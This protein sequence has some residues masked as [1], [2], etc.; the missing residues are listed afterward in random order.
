VTVTFTATDDCGNESFTEATF[1]IEDTGW[2][3]MAMPWQ[4]ITADLYHGQIMRL[5]I[6]D[7]AMTR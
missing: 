1:T 3:T 5:R 2:T 4:L 7:P 6:S